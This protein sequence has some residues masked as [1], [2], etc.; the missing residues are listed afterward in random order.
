MKLATLNA[1]VA[2]AL[3]A[4]L[5]E[6]QAPSPPTEMEAPVLFYVNTVQQPDIVVVLS[7]D[8]VLVRR[9]DLRRAG[10]GPLGGEELM[11]GDESML[12]LSSVCPPLRYEFDEED[13]ALRVFA[14]PELLPRTR[15]DLTGRPPEV[16]Y[17]RDLSGFIN[18]ASQ[19]NDQGQGSIYEETGLSFDGKLLFSSMFLSTSAAPVRG[20]THLLVDEREKL[21]R[22]TLGDALV[23]TGP[24]GGG[25]FVGG[26]TVTRSYDLD[27]YALKTPGFGMTGSTMTP[28][29]LDVYVNGARVRSEQI[30]PGT[31]ELSNV[32][33]GGGAGVAGYVLRDAFG[34]ER[35]VEAPFYM[36][37]A[38]LREGLDEYEYSIGVVRDGIRSESW[39]YSEP[40]ALATHRVGLTNDVTVG[41]RAEAL[42]ERFSGGPSVIY[43]TPFGQIDADLAASFDGGAGPG[44]AGR[45]GYSFSSRQFGV[46][47]FTIL[48]SD[49]YSHSALPPDTD[50]GTVEAGLSGSVPISGLLTLAARGSLVHLRDRGLGT[51]LGAQANVRLMGGLNWLTL[52]TRSSDEIGGLSWEVITTL[53]YTFLG[54]YSAQ[55]SRQINERGTAARF[56]TTKSPPLG[57]GMGYRASATVDGDDVTGYGDFQYQTV[58]GRYG[59]RYNEFTQGRQFTVDAAGALVVVPGVGVYPTMPVQSAF[60]VIR[61]PGVEGVRGYGNHQELGTTDSDG[62]LIVPSLLAYYGNHLSIAPEDVPMEYEIVSTEET[63]AP[64]PRGVALATFRVRRPHFYRGVAVVEVG[65]ERVVPKWGQITVEQAAERV[66]SPLGENGEF[67]L[68]GLDSGTFP[69]LVEWPEGGCAFE[70]EVPEAEEVVVELGEI[71]CSK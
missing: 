22:Y 36:T 32:T 68:E 66:I 17:E 29:T 13:I 71:V 57:P 58:Y 11:I 27:P 69:A 50:R 2:T 7:G 3:A 9:E 10:I 51:L 56:D 24:L 4:A 33:V 15:V 8:E 64:P 12:L 46:G 31:F 5:A 21:R 38:A 63:I 20:V 35:R 42:L 67:E 48:R 6:A 44:A 1:V 60:G 37:S 19:L 18:Y 23:Q 70:L 39:N 61:V 45:L 34:N 65:G 47:A 16:T 40:A 14:P 55:A 53:S 49:H 52:A 54:G 28:A 59:L 30:D 26:L 62:N 43:L 25:G 41:G